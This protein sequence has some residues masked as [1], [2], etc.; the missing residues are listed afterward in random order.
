[1]IGRPPGL[2]QVAEDER[3]EQRRDPSAEDEKLAHEEKVG[4]K[5]IGDRAQPP[6][7]ELV[8]VSRRGG[9]TRSCDMAQREPGRRR[10]RESDRRPRHG[11]LERNARTAVGDP[12]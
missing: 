1:M 5:V 6:A 9:K 3:L 11:H 10:D 2:E 12:G 4:A 8:R 7:G